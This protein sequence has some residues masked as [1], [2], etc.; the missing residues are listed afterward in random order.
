MK[1]LG[2]VCGHEVNIASLSASVVIDRPSERI[3]EG[4]NRMVLDD[5]GGGLKDNDPRRCSRDCG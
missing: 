3:D 2:H 4:D 5:Q 1:A